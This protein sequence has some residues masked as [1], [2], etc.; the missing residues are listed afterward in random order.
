MCQTLFLVLGTI[1]L[2]KQI[3]FSPLWNIYDGR[4]KRQKHIGK[5]ILNLQV[6]EG[7][8]SGGKEEALGGDIGAE[9][10]VNRGSSLCKGP[11]AGVLCVQGGAWRRV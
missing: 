2:T 3:K 5:E 8:Q 7:K 10:Q 6:R 4:K 1:R 11:G 9:T